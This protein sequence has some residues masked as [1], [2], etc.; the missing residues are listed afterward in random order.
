MKQHHIDTK[1]RTH[2]NR[3][4]RLCEELYGSAVAAEFCFDAVEFC[5]AHERDPEF[6]SILEKSH[7][8]LLAAGL[9]RVEDPMNLLPKWRQELAFDLM[10]PVPESVV[11]QIML[12]LLV[13]QPQRLA[14]F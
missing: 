10:P 6:A 8:Q 9:P 11:P 3:N 2:I 14:W 1:M 5:L 4:I 7:P 13:A 12:P